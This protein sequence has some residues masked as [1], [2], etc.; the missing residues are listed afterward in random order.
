M[1]QNDLALQPAASTD[2]VGLLASL[3]VPAHNEQ[4]SIVRCLAALAGDENVARIEVVV[5]ANG[6]TDATAE[7]ARG[8]HDRIP[9]L[10]V[11]ELTEA[12]KSAALNAGD[13]ACHAF[14]RVYLDA[15]IVL[16]GDAL[17]GL[18]REL[19]TP[20][21]RVAS[22]RVRFDT[23]GAAALVRGFYR[24]YERLP[25]VGAG[26]IGLGV[27]ALSEAGRARFDA[28]PDIISDDLFVQRLFTEAERRTS[29]GVFTV[30]TPR[31]VRALLRVRT[32]VAQGNAEL[33]RSGLRDLADTSTTT[34][35]TS[36][37]LLDILREDPRMMAAV[38][39]YTAVIIASRL[40]ARVSRDR[41]WLRD[42]SSRVLSSDASSA[43]RDGIDGAGALSV[44]YLV[45]QYP[46]PSHIFIEREV[47]ALRDQGVRV[48]T[49]SARLTPAESLLSQKMRDE[50]ART[51][52]LQANRRHLLR[53][54][55]RIARQHP[56][57]LGRGV[58]RALST[59][60]ASM[61]SRLKQVA[62]LVQAILLREHLLRDDIRHLHAH[63]ANNG[64][65]IA[66]ATVALG[67]DVDGPS[68]GWRW[69]FSMHG[70]TEFENVKHFDLAAKVRSAS[71]V[72]C[73]T[74][75]TRSQLM[76]LVDPAEWPKLQLVPM[77]VD[78]DRFAPPIPARAHNGA[79]RVLFVG[80]L[81]P[82]KGPS[83]LVDALHSL[84]REV[85]V[86]ARIAGSGPLFEELQADI[87][88][89]G[90]Q[91][92]IHL[93]G[94]VGQDDILDLYHWADVFCLPSFQEGLPVV[95]M[96]AMATGLPVITTPIAGIPELV[97]D[98]LT[99]CLV[100]PGRADVL[101]ATMAKLAGSHE[102]R[103]AL[104]SSARLAVVHRHSVDVARAALLGFLAQASPARLAAPA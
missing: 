14:P 33:A 60:E 39:A 28:F 49:F 43:R 67:L 87:R 30:R 44:A 78:V 50:A 19:D 47:L 6:C 98:H 66:R 89:R 95:L 90:L 77:S 42:D 64:A 92:R 58:L 3:V 21:A 74:D 65:D 79:L 101:A 13:S 83:V 25:Y 5:V 17:T 7:T 45:S 76:R 82:E 40:R 20:G 103:H 75:F 53:A 16:S 2:G 85:E 97:H 34:T 48:E 4:A 32:R 96:E 15:D 24:T 70:P 12:S 93:I 26:L 94:A 18:I 104:G 29:A 91:S 71:A 11:I 8:F 22:P 31:T 62:Y 9:Q 54:G 55:L 1:T 99:G 51:R 56:T 63:F 23:V 100:P 102:Q 80:R 61:A 37:A 10:Q 27:Y 68:S 88:S 36:R 86:E 81:V 46:A 52:S 41:V 59:G 72:A 38:A 84:S 69:T 57:A 73:I 35:A